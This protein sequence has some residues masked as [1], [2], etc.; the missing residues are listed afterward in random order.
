MAYCS[1]KIG[2]DLCKCDSLTNA[3]T[4]ATPATGRSR[5]SSTI[6]LHLG[7]TK[8]PLRKFNR[9][10]LEMATWGYVAW[11]AG[12]WELQPG[13][14][15]SSHQ[16]SP[17]SPRKC[18][19]V[20]TKIVSVNGGKMVRVNPSKISGLCSP[21]SAVW[22]RPRGGGRTRGRGRRSTHPSYLA[23]G[24]WSTGWISW[25]VE[26]DELILVFWATKRVNSSYLILKQFKL[27]LLSLRS[28]SIPTH[29]VYF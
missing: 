14:W 22:G 3:S 29:I 13:R 10:K 24:R 18:I 15:W 5:S 20:S 9:V 16:E 11:I 12:W 23:A 8:H 25:M 21:P 27:R 7:N 1:I 6:A 2:M 19:A 17:A 4:T 26:R 28:R